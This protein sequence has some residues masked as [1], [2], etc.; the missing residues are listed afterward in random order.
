MGAKYPRIG[1]SAFDAKHSSRCK[2]RA[3]D[4]PAHGYVWVQVTYMRGDDEKYMVCKEH[5]TL[6]KTDTRRFMQFFY[7][8]SRRA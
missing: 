1:S 6:A 8:K 4:R 7:D 3:C 5:H 2:C